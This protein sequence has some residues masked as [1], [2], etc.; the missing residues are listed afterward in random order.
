MNCT[1]TKLRA[2]AEGMAQVV[3][4]L[5]SKREALSSNSIPQ[6]KKKKK[7]LCAGW[8]WW[9][10]SVIPAMREDSGL[11][12]ARAMCGRPYPKNS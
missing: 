11:R 5:P 3:E 9:L 12:P 6:K 1:L 10:R 4:C 8:V 7:K 2:L